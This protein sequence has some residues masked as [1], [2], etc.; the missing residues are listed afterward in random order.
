MHAY[1]SRSRGDTVS[2]RTV[3]TSAS[4]ASESKIE[5]ADRGR[6]QSVQSKIAEIADYIRQQNQPAS[7]V[8]CPSYKK[9]AQELSQGRNAVLP[10]VSVLRLYATKE[11]KAEAEIQRRRRRLGRSQQDWNRALMCAYFKAAQEQLAIG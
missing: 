11:I 10:N 9:W 1:Q 2:Q 6:P 8:P 5:A 7:E 4:D 3:Q